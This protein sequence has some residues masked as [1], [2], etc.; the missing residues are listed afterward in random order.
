MVVTLRTS[1]PSLSIRTE[2]M[3]LTGLSQLSISLAALRN[4]SSSSLLFFA[5]D[6]EISPFLLVWM[7]RTAPSL[8]N[9]G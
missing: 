1:Q 3:T 5:S 7:T 8:A 6:S 9:S 4:A 2:T